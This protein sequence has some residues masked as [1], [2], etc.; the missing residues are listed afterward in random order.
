MNEEWDVKRGVVHEEAM[1]FFPMF[2]QAFSMVAAEHDERVLV[3][4]LHFKEMNQASHLRVR[5]SNF[6]IVGMVPIFVSVRS[7]RTIGEMGIVQVH[8][9]KK[10]LLIIL[11]QPIQ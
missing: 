8:P 10:L 7:R 11:T 9:Q 2:S 6:A 3:Q 4:I 5:K 1:G